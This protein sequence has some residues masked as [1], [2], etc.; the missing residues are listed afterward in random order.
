MVITFN[1]TGASEGFPAL[2][3]TCGA[4]VKARINKGKDLRKRSSALINR[5]LLIDFNT[6]TYAACLYGDLNLTEV[7]HIIFTHNHGDHFYPQDIFR[8]RPPFGM[9]ERRAPLFLYGSVSVYEAFVNAGGEKEAVAEYLKFIVLEQETPYKI[10]GTDYEITPFLSNHNGKNCF[11]QSVKEGDK[12]ILY[13]L[14]SGLF[15]QETWDAFVRLKLRFDMV[16]FDCTFGAADSPY[17]SHMGIPDNATLKK[18]MER[19][20]AADENTKYYL[21][22][23]AHA[24]A[25]LYE[26]MQREAEKFGMNS[27]YDNLKVT[28]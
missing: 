24:F 8:I 3:C 6:D 5:D 10:E 22:H 26:D 18:E 4:C 28:V 21:T 13:A 25:P 20:G 9:H 16:V 2:F 11:I 19:L 14:D 7:N 23:F 17:K 12:R 27:A 15:L 1:G